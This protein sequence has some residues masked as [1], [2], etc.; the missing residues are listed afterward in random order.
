MKKIIIGALAGLTGTAV[1]SIFNEVYS[2]TK[3]KA[4]TKTKSS[5]NKRQLTLPSEEN[6]SRTLTVN[7]FLNIGLGT[8]G[9]IGS[10]LFSKTRR[11]TLSEK[12][13]SG[14]VL[15]ST[16]DLILKFLSRKH[17]KRNS[18][19]FVVGNSLY[20][21]VTGVVN[22]TLDR[23]FANAN[24]CKSLDEY[25][26]R[27]KMREEVKERKIKLRSNLKKIK[28]YRDRDT[29]KRNFKKTS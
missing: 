13:T 3:T 11:D 25:V 1:K 28:G 23:Y 4:K 7:S 29:Q 2:A 20:G 16:T 26:D 17:A 5:D 27:M 12:I 9:G 18:F 19:S 14:V 15:G 8:L 21:I 10:Y 22:N 6:K 24:D